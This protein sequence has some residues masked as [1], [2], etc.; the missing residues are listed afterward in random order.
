MNIGIIPDGNRRYAEKKQIPYENAYEKGI[1]KAKKAIKWCGDAGAD[2][3]VIYALSSDNKVKTKRVKL[4]TELYKQQMNK[5]M[6]DKNLKKTRIKFAGDWV[7]ELTEE[8]ILIED[9]TEKNKGLG[10]YIL[11]NYSGK[12]E[13]EK[14]AETDSFDVPIEIDLVI[15]T[16]GKK[17]L[18]G[19]C[20]YQ[21]TY[22][23]IFFTN[24]LWPE[25]TEKEFKE[26]INEFNECDRTYGK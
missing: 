6:N 13:M 24:T 5:A 16:G 17:R 4:L 15:R 18:S 20:P 10:V 19:F 21:S 2:N 7:N 22:A 14:A 1:E 25:F 9:A 8:A 12:K 26:I 23:E 3:V 11:L